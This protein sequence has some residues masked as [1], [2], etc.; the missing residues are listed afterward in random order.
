MNAYFVSAAVFVFMYLSLV[1]VFGEKMKSYGGWVII[2]IFFEFELNI[3]I[4][5]KIVREFIT[6][7]LSL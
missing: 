2:K 4:K 6:S 3:K 1:D 7:N 5:L